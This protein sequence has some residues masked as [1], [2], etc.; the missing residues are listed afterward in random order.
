ML[1]PSSE[2]H[3]AHSDRICKVCILLKFTDIIYRIW[4][5]GSP[6]K[7]NIF[8]AKHLFLHSHIN[9]IVWSCF[10]Y[11]PHVLQA[12]IHVCSPFR[13]GKRCFVVVLEVE[14]LLLLLTSSVNTF[15][16]Q[17]IHSSQ[18]KTDIFYK[19]CPQIRDARYLLSW[20]GDLFK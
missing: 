5:Q 16:C 1:P 7:I 6:C 10:A 12:Q 15:R 3:V 18:L 8:E 4:S 17:Y 13:S 20:F 14:N 9:N 11:L 19:V 2:L